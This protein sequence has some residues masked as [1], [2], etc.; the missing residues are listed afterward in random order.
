MGG[1]WRWSLGL[2]YIVAV[3]AIWIAASYIVQSVV[4]RGV[5][6]FLITYI[7]NSLFIIYIPLAEI[8]RFFEDHVERTR[9][10]GND[11][12]KNEN[13]APQSGDIECVTLL[14]R[15]SHPQEEEEP[16]SA[17]ASRHGEDESAEGLAGESTHPGAIAID[18][19]DE[20]GRWNRTRVAMVSLLIC[21]FWFGAQLS[22]NLSLKYT[23]VTVSSS[24]PSTTSSAPSFSLIIGLISAASPLNFL[25]SNTILS[26]SSSL[27]TFLVSLVFLGEA[28]TWVKLAGVLLCMGGT[29][30]VSLGD[31]EAGAR[32]AASE[33]PLLGDAL[34]LISALLYSVYVTLIRKRLP[35]EAKGEGRASMALFLGY[36]GLFNLL[37]FL[38]VALVL[39]FTELESFRKLSWNQ[40]G[41]IIGKGPYFNY[42]FFLC[43]YAAVEENITAINIHSFFI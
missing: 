29:V 28:F 12:I 25:Q 24:S 9:L 40:L 20:K 37:I 17:I 8:A 4:E 39:E 33:S 22:F 1:A 3:A 32:A 31:T 34:A 11:T 18:G 13:S 6:P 43:F 23:T 7:C 2:V 15:R 42:Y 27:F 41:L 19:A 30:M 36:L 10:P 38:P 35:D 16:A 26:S 5:S 21:P 14:P